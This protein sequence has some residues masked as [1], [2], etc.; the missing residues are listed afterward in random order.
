MTALHKQ[1]EEFHKFGTKFN[2][3]LQHWHQDSAKSVD[4]K[5][6]MI[7]ARKLKIRSV[8]D[9]DAG[10]GE[11]LLGSLALTLDEYFGVTSA[12][13]PLA[14]M[15]VYSEQNPDKFQIAEG[16]FAKVDL[17][18]VQYDMVYLTSDTD[19]DHAWSA[20][21]PTGYLVL[22]GKASHEL[23]SLPQA[24]YMGQIAGVEVW[25]RVPSPVVPD[26]KKYDTLRFQKT[27]NKKQIEQALEIVRQFI[28]AKKRLLTGGMSVDYA[29]KLKGTKLY[30]DDVLP[31]Y[32]LFSPESWTDAYELVLQL[33]DAK[34]TEIDMI[35]AMH[36]TTQRVRVGGVVVA[37]ITY[38]PP[39]IFGAMIKLEYGGM[40]ILHPLYTILDQFTA[41]GMPYENPPH[42]VILE[43]W[44]KD[45]K[46][47]ALLLSYYPLE[48]PTLEL[49]P[50]HEVKIPERGDWI[51]QGWAALAYYDSPDQV[52][53]T[54]KIPQTYV[55]IMTDN[56][57]KFETKDAKFMDSMTGFPRHF[58]TSGLHVYDTL[59]LKI[60][61]LEGTNVVS[62]PALMW[63]FMHKWLQYGDLADHWGAVRT[64]AHINSGKWKLS[65]ATYGKHVWNT[66]FVHYMRGLNDPEEKKMRPPHMK[67][68]GETRPSK[69]PLWDPAVS[70]YFQIQGAPSQAAWAD[71]FDLALL[72][73][74]RV[75]GGK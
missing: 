10:R 13:K 11:R 50:L 24:K 7:L 23:H 29:L 35:G 4:P 3:I 63:Y 15:I 21:S 16:T 20:V 70:P 34:L 30:A 59:G 54:V 56:W 61:I 25:Q 73:V 74:H 18:K 12:A 52:R 14:D 27:E 49:G 33:H 46:R 57:R 26:G 55:T 62:L 44:R 71:P 1:Y 38:V 64:L 58:E 60:G 28:I 9:T 17:R 53:Q 51:L 36:I 42:E 39:N 19:A 68:G 5:P 66:S 47:M 40:Q 31:D 43:R 8:L 72:Q 75:D 48:S 41:L 37:D 6:F 22:D 45:I 67:A 2:E 32:D 65:I 69:I